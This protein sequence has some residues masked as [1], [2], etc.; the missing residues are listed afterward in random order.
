MGF[1]LGDRPWPAGTGWCCIV[2]WVV[3]VLRSWAASC[4]GT[5][6]TPTRRYRPAAVAPSR[7]IAAAAATLAA[8][9]AT[10]AATTAATT[11]AI[12]ATPPPSSPP[13]SSPPPMMLAPLERSHSLK[14]V[15]ALRK[16]HRSCVCV[17][18]PPAPCTSDLL[19]SGIGGQG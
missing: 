7:A 16:E 3:T 18:E 4:T 17:L 12:A 15:E 10:L 13:P 1:F 14:K 9:A 6:R 8:A 19:W 5:R 11:V 2:V